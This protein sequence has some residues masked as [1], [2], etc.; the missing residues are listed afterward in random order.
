MDLTYFNPNSQKEADFLIGF[1]A[2]QRIFSFFLKQLSLAS[3]NGST[4]HYL[5]VAPRGF[6]K[7]SLLRRIAIGIQDDEIL[8]KKFIPLRFREEQ[9]NV[10]SLDVFWRNC[11]QS[12]AEA[13]EDEGASPEE[14]AELDAAWA[15]YAPRQALAKYNQQDGEPAWRALKEYCEKIQRRPVLLL[16]N[17]DILLEGLSDHYQWGLRKILQSD[18]GPILISA[19]SRYPAAI[20]DQKAAFYDFFR[21]QPLERL[22]DEEV[23][24]CLRNLALHRGAAGESVLNLLEKTPGRVAA[25]NTLAGGNPRTLS[26]LY[27]V[28]ESHMNADVL[29]QLSAM[30]DTFTGWY[31]ARTEELPLQARAVFDALA[32]NWDPMTAASLSQATGLD[33][34]TVSSQLTRLEKSGYIDSVALNK[35][36]KGRNG[37]QVSERFF[38]IWYLMRNGPR[39]AKQSIKFLTTFLQMC[40]SFAERRSLAMATLKNV[41]SDP[42][43]AL[44]L[45]SSLRNGELRHQLI[46]QAYVRSNNLG[47]AGEY[48]PLIEELRNE[49]RK[50]LQPGKISNT[51]AGLG[52]QISNYDGVI[53]RFSTSTELS[54]KEQVAKALVNKGITLGALGQREQAIEAYNDVISRFGTTIEF[55]LRAQIAKALVNKGI[56]LNALGQREQAIAVYDDVITRFGTATE[57]PLHAQI[58]KALV[59]KGITLSALGHSDQAIVV[60]DDVIA[61][62][63]TATELLLRAQVAKALVSKGITLGALG[64]SEQAIAVYDEVVA[65]F[66]KATEL[67]L[68]ELLAR[69]LVNKGFMLGVLNQREHAVEVYDEVI[70]RF[71]TATEPALFKK[72]AIALVNKGITL[73]ALG[74]SREEIAVYD[75]VLARFGTATE[76]TLRE[77]VA[78]ALVNKGMTL[79][80]LG[81][82]GEE[83]AVYDEVLARFGTATELT[84]REQVAKALLN[85]GSTLGALGYPK[86]AIVVYD[87]VL[88]RFDVENGVTLRKQ[89]AR[90]LFNKGVALGALDNPEQAIAVYDKVI[91]RFG[92]ATET[93]ILEQVAR[94]L[95][96]KGFTL[97]ALNHSQQEIKAYD[98]V[99]ARFGMLTE[100]ALRQQVAMA[101]VNKGIALG[102]LNQLEQAIATYDEAI[103]RIDTVNEPG[104]RELVAKALNSKGITLSILEQRE[105]AIA[106]YDEVIARFGVA[107]EIDIREQVA[108]ALVNKGFTLGALNHS[109]QEITV[110]DEV[111]ARFGA[112][113]EPILRHQVAM[114]LVN[115]GITLGTL[116]QWEQA[117]TTYDEVISRIDTTNEPD[118]CELVARTLFT[119]GVTLN[120]L[121]QREQAIAVY[122]EVINRFGMATET[123]IREQVAR[124]LVNK[125]FALSAMDHQE[126]A[127]ASFDDAITRFSMETTPDL[128]NSVFM[129]FHSKADSMREIEQFDASEKIYRE[130]IEWDPSFAGFHV[131]LGNLLSDFIGK[132]IDALV[133]FENGLKIV[134]DKKDRA[135]L[136]SNVAYTMALH[137]DN[138][139]SA[140]VHANSAL[141]DGVS[142]SMAGRHLLEALPIWT[143]S[144]LDLEWLH[145]FEKI[146][147][148]VLCED[149]T[150]W[151]D[152]ND[153]LQ[154]LLWFILSKN[155]GLN[156]KKWMEDANFTSKY[157]PLYYAFTAALEGE[158]RLLQINP[159]TRK[160]ALNIYK[161]I[162][163]LVKIWP[164]NN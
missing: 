60:C 111:V 55:P 160:P 62:F 20:H 147:K 19:A 89:V 47:Q 36:G 17:L 44:A 99:I 70:A 88:A 51:E 30:L 53:A 4:R 8:H 105:Q 154:R 110:Y 142:I 50:Q 35:R 128:R 91:A 100:P 90:T 143:N 163:R 23:F 123:D 52:K 64:D 3:D 24:A 58:A 10:I 68:S 11:L 32:L 86:K 34:P 121:G 141:E 81:H 94:A 66:G 15:N 46:D 80:A 45:A 95:L 116:G 126:R 82:S 9:H 33:T 139:F 39:R 76:L 109:E 92:M 54:S 73:G 16:D 161:G 127:I 106:V 85:K 67:P 78:R 136:N 153:D 7:T 113:T 93:D 49:D 124:A 155:Q 74:H 158:D 57:F 75:E 71:G 156:F 40:F 145:I 6:G 103:S 69:A 146:G 21:I 140:R 12:L 96:N 87:E 117:I 130:A 157:A 38:N 41:R 125:G 26:V 104:L 65:R 134:K 2:R 97:G 29:S 122:D 133:A 1:V 48:G 144:R 150:L 31:Q 18:N 162:D 98:D 112:A 79:G 118:L 56:T 132:P 42:S 13:R 63:G 131:G 114:A 102:N 151:A 22:D 25:L 149:P 101:L 148:A 159:E 83:I 152:Y 108:R 135:L 138:I 5:I 120:M 84:L 119:K 164:F 115:K 77:Q 61:R 72:V 28:L 129:A 37:Y 59:N 43:Y 137:S 107:T 27:G 14:I